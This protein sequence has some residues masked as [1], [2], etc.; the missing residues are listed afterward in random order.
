M[1]TAKRRP[2]RRDPGSAVPAPD[3]RD[4][5]AFPDINFDSSAAFRS[6]KKSKGGASR[7]SSKLMA[8]PKPTTSSELI[9]PSGLEPGTYVDGQAFASKATQGGAASGGDVGGGGEAV[10]SHHTSMGEVVEGEGG[11]KWD[12]QGR[13]EE[14]QIVSGR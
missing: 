14:A 6:N 4:E 7:S 12:G 5:A 13:I 8:S 10:L 2:G 11:G 1:I 9:T 3:V